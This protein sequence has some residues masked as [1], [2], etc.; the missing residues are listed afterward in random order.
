ME[1]RLEWL[2]QWLQ[3]VVADRLLQRVPVEAVAGRWVFQGFSRR[4]S[5]DAEPTMGRGL[6]VVRERKFETRNSGE[7]K[8]HDDEF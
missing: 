5:A 4:T 7:E 3:S 2:W 1:C 6:G 8:V